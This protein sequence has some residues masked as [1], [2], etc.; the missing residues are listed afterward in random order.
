MPPGRGIFMHPFGSVPFPLPFSRNKVA[1]PVISSFYT[2]PARPCP[3][4]SPDPS[5]GLRMARAA[6]CAA[7]ANAPGDGFRR[8]PRSVSSVSRGPRTWPERCASFRRCGHIYN[9]TYI[10]R[11]ETRFSAFG[12]PQCRRPEADILYRRR[13]AILAASPRPVRTSFVHAFI[14]KSSI[15]SDKVMI[16]A[17]S[18]AGIRPDRVDFRLPLGSYDM[19]ISCLRALRSRCLAEPCKNPAVQ[20]VSVPAAIRV[21]EHAYRAA[22][23]F[24]FNTM[25]HHERRR[26]IYETPDRRRRP[27][28]A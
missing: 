15:C 14:H 21:P 23:S 12:P 1:A 28:T 13:A 18:P 6:R 7:C 9:D 11:K 27:Q 10:I 4:F 2:K 16:A 25:Q 24:T 17:S 19:L 3:A 5:P 26:R 20:A 22:P 8:F